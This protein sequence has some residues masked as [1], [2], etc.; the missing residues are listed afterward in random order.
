MY[1]WH[2]SARLQEKDWN[3]WVT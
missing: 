3:G 1:T 2:G